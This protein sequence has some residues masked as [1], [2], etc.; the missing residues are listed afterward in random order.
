M[1]QGLAF[2]R[3][4]SRLCVDFLRI[5]YVAE[6]VEYLPAAGLGLDSVGCL[7]LRIRGAP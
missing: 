5:V 7:T 6:R 4:A 1:G 2:Q 3:A